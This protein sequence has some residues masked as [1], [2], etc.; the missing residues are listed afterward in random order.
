[1][2]SENQGFSV[3]GFIKGFGKL[4][5]G[6][7]LLLQG[8]IGLV[9][10]LLIVGV[11]VSVSDNLAGGKAA[12]VDVPKGAALL[13]NPQG[14]LVEQAEEVDPFEKALEEAYGV[15]EPDQVEARDII[16]AIRKAKTDE[17]VAGLVLDLGGLY[18]PASSASKLH[19]IAA[20]IEDFKTSEKPVIAVGDYYS[21]EQYLIAS[22]ADE[23][24]MHGF[25]NVVLYGY[26]S[27]EAYIKSLLEKLKVTSHIFRVGT[28]KS[29]VEPFMRDDMSPEAKEANLAYLSVLWREYAASVEKARALPQGSVQ[30]YAD[31]MPPLL[32]QANGDFAKLAQRYG[33]VDDLKS[34]PQQLAYLKEKFGADKD[35][36]SFKHVALS[37]YLK[38]VGEAEPDGEAPNIALVTAAGV[39]VDGEA[40]AG[41]AAGGDTI[42]KLLKKA[43]D[44]EN[45]KAVVFR[46]DSP[47]GSAF[48]SEIIRER[49]LELK[50]AGKPVVVSMGSLAASGGYWISSPADEIWAAPTTITGSIGIFGLLTTFENTA[51]EI[52][53]YVDGVGTSRLSPLIATGVGPLPEVAAE[54]IQ[55]S[56]EEGYER[57]LRV[58]SEG[59]G[60]ERDYIDS[61]GQG[62][63]WIGETAQGLK[64]VDKLGDLDAAVAAAAERAGLE[65][66]DVVEM[67][68]KLTPF[69]R[70]FGGAA[71]RAMKLAGLDFA[72][73]RAHQSALRKLFAQ[74]KGE[75]ELLDSFN[76]PS[77]LYARCL[78]CELR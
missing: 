34:R 15:D 16:R 37:R 45:V 57:F 65:E 61:I 42:A 52:G 13:L 17:R 38:A 28:F 48:A 69:Q 32:E 27:Y 3:W 71:A 11:I 55:Q 22:R 58:V 31:E 44:D 33:L 29:A 53:V 78:S 63:V 30:R 24:L 50:E 40:P 39:I 43:H 35:G 56:V 23:I 59:R 4:L 20:A 75:I 12:R 14:V 10:M 41:V 73:A 19:D 67:V 8:I 1:M 9:V 76:D 64:L 7:L 77:G 6:F 25:G 51:A 68:E 26:G 66:Y 49:L 72:E 18:A 47:G 36:K 74:I 62:R 46:V 70:I 5:I 54:L 2:P 60:L 21:Q